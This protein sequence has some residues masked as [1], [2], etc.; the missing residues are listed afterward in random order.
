MSSRF[1]MGI[2][3][4]SNKSGVVVWERP[5]KK[6]TYMGLL[7]FFELYDYLMMFSDDLH[8]RIEAGWLIPKINWHKP[9]S[10]QFISA[11]IGS[12][13][14][15]NHETGKKI[16]EMC[17]YLDIPYTLVKPSNKKLSAKE[18]NKMVGQSLRTNQEVRDAAML[19]YG[20]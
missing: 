8:I 6:F 16:A 20:I 5:E 11:K 19:V 9:G 15:A 4:D 12:F 13:V 14:G 10:N 1:Y 17:D 7:G 18:F 3:P 2:D